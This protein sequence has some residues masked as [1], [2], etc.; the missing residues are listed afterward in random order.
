MMQ[1][2]KKHPLPQPGTAPQ[3]QS[4]CLGRRRASDVF[5]P[6]PPRFTDLAPARWPRCLDFIISEQQAGDAA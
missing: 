1:L 4:I 3:P 5:D 6:L 2:P